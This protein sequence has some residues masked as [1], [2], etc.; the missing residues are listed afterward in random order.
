MEI[1]NMEIVCNVDDENQIL[2]GCVDFLDAV[3]S[4]P[5][6][7]NSVIVWAR[8]DRSTRD[9]HQRLCHGSGGFI[10]IAR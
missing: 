4:L 1:E 2:E 10:A 8:C 9:V 5:F 3:T 7:N 6:L